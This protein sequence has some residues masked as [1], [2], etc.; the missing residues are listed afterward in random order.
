MNSP[1]PVIPNLQDLNTR[2]Y[3]SKCADK[4]SSEDYCSRLFLYRKN[5]S[6]VNVFYHDCIKVVSPRSSPSTSTPSTSSNEHVLDV[7][8]WQSRNADDLVA[9]LIGFFRFYAT[10]DTWANYIAFD[11]TPHKN[12]R[13]KRLVL[14]DPFVTS[15]NVA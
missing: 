5:V 2:C 11:Q 1:E 13:C 4:L 10:F 8:L 3:T 12:R 6:R 15:K 14:Y 9:L 7:T